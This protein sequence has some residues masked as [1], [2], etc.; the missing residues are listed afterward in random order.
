MRNRPFSPARALW[1]AAA[2]LACSLPAPAPCRAQDPGAST[3][4]VA[5]LDAQ[6][7][8]D[9]DVTVRGAGHGRVKF[10]MANTSNRRLNVV[11]PPGLV[12]AATTSQGFQSMGLGVPTDQPGRFGRYQGPTA[13][14][15]GFRSMPAD[16]ADGE[17]EGVAV[18]PGQTVEVYVPAVCLNFGVPTPTPK[19]VFRLVSVDDYTPDPRARKALRS[20][21]TLGTSQGVAQAVAWHVFNGMT[22]A[23]MAKLASQYLNASE[24]SVA[25]RFVEALDAS[26][27]HETVDPAYFRD[28]RILVRV[29]GEGTLGKVAARLN[30]ELAGTRV[31]G[32]PVQVVEEVEPSHSRPASLLVDVV[33]SGDPAG[34]VGARALV[35]FN[36]AVGGWARLGG[37]DLGRNLDVNAVNGEALADVIDRAL[38]AQ[39]VSAT[40]ARRGEGTTTVRI[41]NRLPFTLA[42]VV[43]RTGRDDDA[44]RVTVESFGLGPFRNAFAS[45]QAPGGTVERVVLNGL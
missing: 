9:L 43:L 15:P 34:R 20:L 44:P 37:V 17:G 35:R 1:P 5:I 6:R 11:L 21:A 4:T 45:I 39:Y 41:V 2:L 30:G 16:E 24:I 27:A 38:A 32:L 33:L 42:D 14:G 31:F 3:E 40:P 7:A 25:A 36:S 18:S 8:G 12:A 13:S 22:Y 19:D 28:G 10:A 29:R 23:Q 26:A